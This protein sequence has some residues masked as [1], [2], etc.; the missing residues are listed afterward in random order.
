MHTGMSQLPR[1]AGGVAS[2]MIW[3]HAREIAALRALIMVETVAAAVA[4]AAVI[5]VKGE[6]GP[7][8]AA[9]ALTKAAKVRASFSTP[10]TQASLAASIH[11]RPATQLFWE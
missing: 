10:D 7:V 2:A 11:S 9:A 6:N 5:T 8:T 3:S 4:P 1:W